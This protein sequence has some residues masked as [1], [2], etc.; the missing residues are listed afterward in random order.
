MVS[1]VCSCFQMDQ[2]QAFYDPGVLDLV[3]YIAPEYLT[4]ELIS[5]DLDELGRMIDR[6]QNVIRSR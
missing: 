6:Q 1:G 4:H 2:H 5:R 3:Q